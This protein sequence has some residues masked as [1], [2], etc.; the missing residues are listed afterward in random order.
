MFDDLNVKSDDTKDT[1]GDSEQWLCW[2]TVGASSLAKNRQCI[3]N[4]NA[5]G[6]LTAC[7]FLL[8][9]TTAHSVISIK[10]ICYPSV[11]GTETSRMAE[12]WQLPCSK[13][14]KMN[15]GATWPADSG[16]T[17]WARYVWPYPVGDVWEWTARPQNKCPRIHLHERS[18]VLSGR[19][20]FLRL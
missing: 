16:Q 14:P 4:V 18:W 10:R 17:D 12:N 1:L 9:R 19:A 7:S 6:R 20:S 3:I 2:N 8:F 15:T 11:C 5:Y 13:M